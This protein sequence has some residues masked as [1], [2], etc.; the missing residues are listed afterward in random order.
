MNLN[1]KR[2]QYNYF[3]QI[4]CFKENSENNKTKQIKNGKTGHA[5]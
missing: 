1:I 3:R 2:V 4:Q 5:R